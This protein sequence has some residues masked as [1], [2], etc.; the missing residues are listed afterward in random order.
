M[1]ANKSFKT[2]EVLTDKANVAREKALQI[3]A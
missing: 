1:R 3:H 2:F